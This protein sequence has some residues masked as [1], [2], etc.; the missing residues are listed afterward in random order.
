MFNNKIKF[1]YQTRKNYTYKN[2]LLIKT[3]Y[4]TLFTLNFYFI[5][6]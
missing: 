5:L 1:N 2:N 3:I 4:T 6:Y